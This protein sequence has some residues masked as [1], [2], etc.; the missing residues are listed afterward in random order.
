MSV[1]SYAYQLF[2]VEQCQA[3]IHTLRWKNRPLQCPRGHRT[4]SILGAPITTGPGAN[5]TGATAASAP[6]TTSPPPACPSAHGRWRTGSSRPFCCAPLVRLG[7]L[8]G[9]W[10]AIPHELSLVLVATQ[11][12]L[13]RSDAVPT[14]RHGRSG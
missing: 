2:S 9:R 11:R 10:E 12:D 13:V 8:R 7:A 14:G 4:M 1:L 5:A 6:A 3:Y